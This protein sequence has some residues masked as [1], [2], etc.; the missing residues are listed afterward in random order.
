MRGVVKIEDYFFKKGYHLILGYICN[1]FQL[2]T[3]YL[4]ML[5]HVKVCQMLDNVKQC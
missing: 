1:Q 2:K 4:L 3:K 5:Y